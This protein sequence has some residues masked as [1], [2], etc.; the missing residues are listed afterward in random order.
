MKKTIPTSISHTIFYIEIDAYEKLDLYLS[1][2]R[3][4]FS[5]FADNKD[6]IEDIENRIE[7]QL[8]DLC[9]KDKTDR[10]VKSEYIDILIAS[11]GRPE[12][13]GADEENQSSATS[14]DAPKTFRK[15]LYR[16]TDN[17]IIGGVAS[18]LA[19]YFGIDPVIVRV[20]FFISVF[21]GGF[22]IIS[23]LFLWFA[24]PEAKT[25]TEKLEMEGSPVT[26]NEVKKIIEDK[27]EEIKGKDGFKK[28][29]ERLREFFVRMSSLFFGT[30]GKFIGIALGIA[31]L[32]G[33]VALV[34]GLIILVSAIT[35]PI[36]GITAFSFYGIVG[37]V[38][39]LCLIP[40]LFIG[41]AGHALLRS[42]KSS[43]KTLIG[44]LALIWILTAIA[45]TVIGF[46][47]VRKR[48]VYVDSIEHYRMQYLD[49]LRFESSPHSIY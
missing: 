31:A 3:K 11:M 14:S 17:A 15:K 46:H 4:Y 40:I 13:F 30:F 35:L 23:Y 37:V 8:L 33:T 36:P 25:A 39:L 24:V 34:T 38:F 18:G 6:I 1:E 20:L 22:G 43:Y 29:T 44:I 27:V 2:I 32:L 7:E 47:V 45:A 16:D 9:S 41:L 21:L 12:E 19:Q 42:N 48:V 28:S 10:I 5:N 26:L 49:D